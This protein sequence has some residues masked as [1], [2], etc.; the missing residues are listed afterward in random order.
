MD[1]LLVNR[2][3]GNRLKALR[4]AAAGDRPAV[5]SSLPTAGAAFPALDLGT[6][7]ACGGIRATGSRS[8]RGQEQ[9]R[10]EMTETLDTLLAEPES[11]EHALT[12]EALRGRD[13]HEAERL[14]DRF[15][16]EL[17]KMTAEERVRASR[18][19]MN[20]WERWVYAARYPDEVPLVNGELEWIALY[21][22]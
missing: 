3:P 5:R 4:R 10:P 2:D 22:E 20:R 6:P 7:A 19:S 13:V 17:R 12:Y 16:D 9:R 15:A 1:A 21:A 8:G 18:Y 14:V 11:T